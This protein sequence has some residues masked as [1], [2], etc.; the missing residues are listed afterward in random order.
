MHSTFSFFWPRPTC[1]AS[2]NL[3]VGSGIDGLLNSVG[4]SMGKDSFWVRA[5]FVFV[6]L[7]TLKTFKHT[8][9]DCAFWGHQNLRIEL[10]WNTTVMPQL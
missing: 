3:Q 1:Q 2:S 9:T 10:H 5:F 7:L 8:R 6:R 4:K